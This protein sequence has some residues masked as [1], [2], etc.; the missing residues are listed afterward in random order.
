MN[1]F[2]LRGA[3]SAGHRFFS[4]NPLAFD[5]ASLKVAGIVTGV[6]YGEANEGRSSVIL[7]AKKPFK[8]EKVSIPVAGADGKVPVS[9]ELKSA[10]RDDFDT[11]LAEQRTTTA[12]T[13]STSGRKSL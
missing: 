8:V 3:I 11:A 5:P 13:S 12:S 4:A 1:W 6:R 10:S 2:L 7:T 9:I